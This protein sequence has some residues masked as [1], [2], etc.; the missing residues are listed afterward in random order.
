MV[1][2]G[3]SS[4]VDTCHLERVDSISVSRYVTCCI[5]E[6]NGSINEKNSPDACYGGCD[7]GG[8]KQ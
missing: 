1:H 3:D 8:K 4:S 7:I 6:E 5:Y 2:S